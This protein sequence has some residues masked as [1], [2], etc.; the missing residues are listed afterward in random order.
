[1]ANPLPKIGELVSGAVKAGGN[2]YIRGKQA[3]RVKEL[4]PEADKLISSLMNTLSSYLKGNFDGVKEQQTG[5]AQLLNAERQGVKDNYISFLGIN[6]NPLTLSDTGKII[7]PA[8]KVNGKLHAQEAK[9]SLQLSGN[10]QQMRFATFEQDKDLLKL[11]GDL[12]ALQ[13]AY[14][15]TLT[16]IE[17]LKNAHHQ[18][19][20]NIQE[21]KTLKDII[22]NLEDYGATVDQLY[23]SF[24]EI[25]K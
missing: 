8:Q 12:D 3:D 19:T 7:L 14:E 13:K 22:T 9:V 24:K 6:Q 2:L 10:M 11:L 23:D 17:N 4:V 20:E 1:V 21:K 25:K 5:F 15:Q 18:L 16:A